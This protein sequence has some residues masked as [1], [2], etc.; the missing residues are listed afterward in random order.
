MSLVTVV[1]ATANGNAAAGVTYVLFGTTSGFG[2]SFNLADVDGFNGVV[3]NGIN[4]NDSSGVSVSAAGDVNNDGFDDDLIIGRGSS[5]GLL[6][7]P[8]DAG[9]AYVVFGFAST[10]PPVN[11]PTAGD[12]DLTG[13]ASGD[14]IRALSGDDVVRG[15]GG[16]DRLF[17]QDGSD[18]LLGGSGND[19]LLGGDGDDTLNGGGG[20]DFFD[21]GLG[22][23]KI[24]TGKGLDTILIG[25]AE[26][27][28]IVTDFQNRR[29]LIQLSGSLTFE[30][31]TLSQQGANTE[32]A[33]GTKTLLILRD[34][35][36]G[37]IN[38]ADFV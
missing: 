12:D 1:G 25:K 31:L 19:R 35:N 30:D 15:N 33:V 4:E 22:N 20:N 13:T 23:D 10:T 14:T 5:G 34:I 6:S 8:T 9:E 18:R 27:R 29:D 38:Q 28:D 37:V 3:I 24:T 7:S 17:G 32:I 16:N 11:E 36:V 26:R 21:G 2:A